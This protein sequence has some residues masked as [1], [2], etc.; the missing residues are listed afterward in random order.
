MLYTEFESIALPYL[1]SKDRVAVMVSGGFDSA[2]LLYSLCLIKSS[3]KLGV[4][5]STFTVP[6]HNDSERYSRMVTAWV[7]NKFNLDL[8]PTICG[9]P[10]LA[11]NQVVKSGIAH[12]VSI[13]PNIII[14][15]TTNPSHLTNLSSAPARTRA[16]KIFQPFI[17]WTKKETVKLSIDLDLDNLVSLTHSC[18][19]KTVRCNQCWQCQERA[20]GYAENAY[21]DPGC[22]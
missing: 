19:E 22:Y 15:E 10:D 13:C 16:L 8:T 5:I 20:W 2:V 21:P 9:D 7:G 3:H 18:T 14:A 1:Q 6:L 11:H 4:N 17:N 12:A